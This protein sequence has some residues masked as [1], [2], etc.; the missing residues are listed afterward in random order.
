MTINEAMEAY[1]LPNPTTREDLESRWNTV[2]MFGDKV[3]VSGYY[4]QHNKP[5]YYGAAYEYMTDDHSCEG[6]IALAAVS[7][8]EHEDEGHALAWAMQQ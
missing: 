8:V 1:R 5:C 4:Y 7:E 6:V 3:L 2:I